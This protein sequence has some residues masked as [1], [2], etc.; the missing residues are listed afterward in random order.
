MSMNT[1]SLFILLENTQDHKLPQCTTWYC[2][3]K[4]MYNAAHYGQ[5]NNRPQL[6]LPNIYFTPTSKFL[7]SS[8][9]CPPNQRHLFCHMFRPLTMSVDCWPALHGVNIIHLSPNSMTFHYLAELLR[10]KS[11]THAVWEIGWTRQIW[12][13]L[14]RETEGCGVVAVDLFQNS[15]FWQ[16]VICLVEWPPLW[17]F[18]YLG[19]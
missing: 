19:I 7:H 2:Q 6:E 12:F 4:P 3:V 17:S 10:K 18:C 15:C 5:I 9:N 1:R 14:F 16:V 11:S 13:E 8:C